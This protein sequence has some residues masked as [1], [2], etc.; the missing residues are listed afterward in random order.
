MGTTRDDTVDRSGG[1][2]AGFEC[3]RA[4][5]TPDRS[6]LVYQAEGPGPVRTHLVGAGLLGDPIAEITSEIVP[7]PAGAAGSEGG[8]TRSVAAPLEEDVR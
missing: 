3:E 7:R 8:R 1:G 6:Y 4:Y 2:G 5:F